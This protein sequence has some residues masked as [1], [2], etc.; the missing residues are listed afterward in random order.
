MDYVSTSF[1]VSLADA[2]EYLG[3]TSSGDDGII[4]RVLMAIRAQFDEY[5]DKT[6]QSGVCTEVKSGK[7]SDLVT[8]RNWPMDDT[9]G[10]SVYFD[11]NG[12][13]GAD[14][15]IPSTSI[16]ADY[17][18]GII[19]YIGG[20]FEGRRAIKIVYTGPKG[21]AVASVPADIQLACFEMLGYWKQRQQGK[22]WNQSG[23]NRPDGGGVTFQ[24][25]GMPETVKQ[26][27]DPYRNW[28]HDYL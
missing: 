4:G 20:C 8:V 23:V 28:D 12:I 24:V 2:K 13:F 22:V 7:G 11:P 1:L 18:A 27:L 6:L 17:P 5:C 15:L 25:P 21:Y 26:L 14:T 19:Q 9:A 10:L 16:S 3:S